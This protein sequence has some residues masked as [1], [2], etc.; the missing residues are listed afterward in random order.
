M[1]KTRV[2]GQIG[3]SRFICRKRMLVFGLMLRYLGQGL[4]SIFFALPN[5][6]KTRVLSVNRIL[7]MYYSKKSSVPF[8]FV[9][10]KNTPGIAI[11]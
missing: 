2:V 6:V 4:A 3:I 8:V 9:L 7:K 11:H 5:K 10:N 1:I